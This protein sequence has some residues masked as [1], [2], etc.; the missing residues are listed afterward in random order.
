[1]ATQRDR[2]EA[3]RRSLE[4]L[5]RDRT[6]VGVEWFQYTDEPPGGRYDGEDHNFGL[7]D[8]EDRPYEEVTQVCA[9][10][11]LDQAWNSRRA[12]RVDAGAG[13]PPAPADPFERL[14]YMTSL[15]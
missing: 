4:L 15:I 6:V 11:N 7:V 5:A 1:A 8:I 2:A 10:F 13:V 9:T 14:G 3:A 12:A